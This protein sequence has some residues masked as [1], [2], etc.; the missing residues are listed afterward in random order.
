MFS[1]WKG[2]KTYLDT[3][4]EVSLHSKLVTNTTFRIYYMHYCVPTLSMP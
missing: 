1:T 4:E 2:S 3:G